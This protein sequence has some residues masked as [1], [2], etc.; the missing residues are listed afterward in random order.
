[1]KAN[2]FFAMLLAGPM[3]VSCSK[4]TEI[5]EA[6]YPEQTVYMPAAVE[7]I[8]TGGVFFINKVAVPGQAYRFTIDAAAK[9]LHIPLAAYRSGVEK[10]GAIDALIFADADT[11]NRML[12]A[13]KLPA[14]SELLPAG[15]YS[16]PAGVTIADGAGEASFNFSVDL[17]FLVA[18]PTKKFAMAVGVNNNSK[19]PTPNRLA[20]LLID[21]SFLVPVANFTTSVSGKTVSFSNTSVN[22]INY[23]W[24]YGDGSQPSTATAASYT[25]AAAGKYTVTLTATGALGTLNPSIKTATVT[26]L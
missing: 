5:M 24:N 11:T 6:V 12:A 23:S 17:D 3:L 4:E 20:T 9:R 14:G 8:A 13:G 7:G 26:I 2:F 16:L 15:R 19:L 1:M 10:S 25:Y 18:N 21:A 22:G